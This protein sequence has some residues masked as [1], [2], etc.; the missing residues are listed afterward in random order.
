MTGTW[1]FELLV[2]GV[3]TN[4]LSGSVRVLKYL[5]NI[6]IVLGPG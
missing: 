4:K 1:A 5:E 2:I 3:N 6:I